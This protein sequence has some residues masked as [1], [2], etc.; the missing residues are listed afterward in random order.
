MNTHITNL[1]G[2]NGVATIIL[3]LT[4]RGYY[5]YVPINANSP[6]DLMV[7]DGENGRWAIECKSRMFLTS[8]DKIYVVLRTIFTK[9]SG[10]T[11]SEKNLNAIDVL[12]IYAPEINK[13]A[14]LS[15]KENIK[16]GTH[17][18]SIHDRPAKNNQE[19]GYIEFDKSGIFPPVEKENKNV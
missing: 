18:V 6:C 16:L 3:D 19:V 1:S 4:R 9:R 11:Y 13:I 15:M 12:A 10:V 14:Y 2:D 8:R 17:S 7:S 5:V